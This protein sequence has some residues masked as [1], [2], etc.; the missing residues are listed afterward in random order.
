M[1]LLF[2]F[3]RLTSYSKS[4]FS[5]LGNTRRF[6]RDEWRKKGIEIFEI[7]KEVLCNQWL[8][9]GSIV[10]KNLTSKV[11]HLFAIQHNNVQSSSSSLT[12]LASALSGLLQSVLSSFVAVIR[13]CVLQQDSKDYIWKTKACDRDRC[14][15]T[16]W[17]N[18]WTELQDHK[19]PRQKALG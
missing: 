12:S 13:L 3:C 9:S 10:A 7:K 4:L 15:T 5:I 19:R 18:L 6:S 14:R 2:T 8:F 11:R 1:S 16:K 17:P